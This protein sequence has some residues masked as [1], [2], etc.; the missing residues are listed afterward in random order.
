MNVLESIKDWVAAGKWRMKAVGWLIVLFVAS[1]FV[2]LEV[3]FHAFALMDETA[4]NL[5]RLSRVFEHP[6]LEVSKSRIGDVSC[7]SHGGRYS[8]VLLPEAEGPEMPPS[9][10][11]PNPLWLRTVRQIRSAA[12]AAIALDIDI[13]QSGTPAKDL[14][15]AVRSGPNPVT[16]PPRLAVVVLPNFE[17]GD[18]G[19]EHRRARNAFLGELCARSS[20]VAVSLASANISHSRFSNTAVQFHAQRVIGDRDAAPLVYPALGQMGRL[21]AERRE[22][23]DPVGAGSMCAYLARRGPDGRLPFVEPSDPAQASDL[24]EPG[25]MVRSRADQLYSLE[26]LNPVHVASDIPVLSVRNEDELATLEKSGESCLRGRLVFVGRWPG[27]NGIDAFSTA[28]SERTPGAF[29]HA[30]VARSTDRGL[31]SVIAI[32]AAV[33][34]LV[35]YLLALVPQ[36]PLRNLS[37]SESFAV[38][39]FAKVCRLL[40]PVLVILVVC[41]LSIAALNVGWLLN[42]LVVFLGMW[43]HSLLESFLHGEKAGDTLDAGAQNPAQSHESAGSRRAWR[44]WIQRVVDRLPRPRMAT[45]GVWARVD[46]F[47]YGSSICIVVLT[48]VYAAVLVVSRLRLEAL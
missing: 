23:I 44:N 39:L 43:L 2:I 28:V 8:V 17:R 32:N 36:L 26:W 38:R 45:T 1:I 18:K 13:T 29:V 22:S 14:L 31:R 40:A 25:F 11:M 4:L 33:D 10:P 3:K 41:V 15:A 24:L 37:E 16:T 27:P 35:G 9:A 48:I 6:S 12:P 5:L 34:L 21:L 30:M 20:E 47:V 46:F 19:V 42:P 7:A